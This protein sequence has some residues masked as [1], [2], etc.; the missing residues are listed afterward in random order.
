MESPHGW[1]RAFDPVAR[2]ACLLG[3]S[4]INARPWTLLET[5][6]RDV[7]SWS[8]RGGHVQVRVGTP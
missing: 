2:L 1:A 5:T 4:D 6:A 7:Q 3:G 8:M